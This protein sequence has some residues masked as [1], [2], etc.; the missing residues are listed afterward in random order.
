M[1]GE[2]KEWLDDVGGADVPD[3]DSL[4]ADAC[5]PSYKYDS[6]TRIILESKDD[7]GKRR[8]RSPDEWD[9]VALTFAEPVNPEIAF[10]DTWKHTA[11]RAGWMAN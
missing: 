6:L 3:S 9:A 7:I 10:V 1:W 8:L 2:S 11:S 4:Q 5:A